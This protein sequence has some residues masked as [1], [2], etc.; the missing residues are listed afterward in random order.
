LALIHPF[1]EQ[2]G[3]SK[4]KKAIV[5][6]GAGFI[7][8]ALVEELFT[9]GI[10]VT[11]IVR[12]GFFDRFQASPLYGQ[13]VS[14][15]E[16]DLRNISHVENLMK[17]RGFD[18][19]YHLA[20]EGVSGNTLLNYATQIK[21]IEWTM[22]AVASAK[23]LGCKKFIGA[24]SILQYELSVEKEGASNLH[25]KYRIYKVA[26][27]ACERIG[28]SVAFDYKIEFIWPIITNIYGPGEISPRLINSM[29]R[30]LL[31]GKHQSL[32][33]GNQYYDFIYVT[34]AAK[35]FRL[36]GDYGKEGRR[37]VVSG[38]TVQPLRNFLIQVRDI[39][40]PETE[41][42]F[43]ESPF[44]GIYLPEESYGIEKLREDTGFIP[45]VSFEEGIQNTVNW[46]IRKEKFENH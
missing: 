22:D 6:G 45:E 18:V 29:I 19:W 16:C 17:S 15:L 10:E 2:G 25:D 3:K 5:C 1:Y 27:E 20:W 4:V 9:H 23:K 11:A 7:G 13:D 38:G 43:G 30:N 36:I 39:V 35:A 14:I 33:E 21:N 42:G 40:A 41:L 37:Y 46:I 32:S 24:G 12:P 34:D 31:S 26:K 8:R 28:R 44:N